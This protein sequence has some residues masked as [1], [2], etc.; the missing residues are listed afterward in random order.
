MS[1]IVEI[2][3]Q[4]VDEASGTFDNIQASGSGAADMITS[5]WKEI[6]VAAGAAGAGLELVARSQQQLTEDTRKLASATGESEEAI[7]DLALETSNVT[8]PLQDVL[9]LM[10]QAHALGI[11]GADGLQQYA[12]FW[13]MVADATGGNAVAL[14]EAGV[15]LRALG[16]EAGNESEALDAF[17][18]I[19]QNTT[20]SIEDFLRFVERSGPELRDMGM[21]VDDTAAMLGYLQ[22]EFGMSARVARTEFEQAVN[23]SGGSMEKLYEILG[24]SPDKFGEYQQAVSDSS[25]VIETYRDINN[26]TYTTLQKLQHMVSET[27]YKFGDLI[28]GIEPL[29]PMLMGVAPAVT[30]FAQLAPAAK[31]AGGFLPL[32]SGGLAGIIPAAGGVVAALLPFLPVIL[33]LIAAGAALYYAWQTNFLGIQDVVASAKDWIS[34][35]FDGIKSAMEPVKEKLGELA[36]KVGDAFGKLFGKVDELFKK[37]SGGVS[38]MEFVSKAFEALGRVMDWIWEII[39]DKLTVAIDLLTEGLVWLIEQI[40][41]VVDWFIKLAE[42]PIVSWLI[43]KVGAAVGFVG[44]QFDKILP[45]IENADAAM[46]DTTTTADGLTTT[47]SDLGDTVATAGGLMDTTMSD[48]NLGVAESLNGMNTAA[49]ETGKVF[50]ATA[51]DIEQSFTAMLTTV[52]AAAASA[53]S[54][55]TSGSAGSPSGGGS[56]PPPGEIKP[57]PGEVYAY[58]IPQGNAGSIGIGVNGAPVPVD[59]ISGNYALMIGDSGSWGVYVKDSGMA[60]GWR[61]MAAGSSQNPITQYMS[62][63]PQAVPRMARGGTVTEGG[64]VITGEEGPE[65]AYLPKGAQVNSSRTPLIDYDELARAIS[66]VVGK[67]SAGHH[68]HIGTMIADKNGIRKLVR[69]IDA[70]LGEESIRKGGSST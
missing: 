55:A 22:K 54:I 65:L 66:R 42:N 30:I 8:F 69:E 3:V 67:G 15:A 4:A 11:E 19:T 70:V 45:P 53:N 51:N 29:A 58:M 48:T 6:A 59:Y 43:D 36:S 25:G 26:D 56:G 49:D 38:I 47:F 61:T 33:L 2:I 27:A 52:R 20:M 57:Y 28:G 64:I 16:I 35:R 40:G 18:Y 14:G 21:D 62:L 12:N 50:D 31:A 10:Q 39:G 46:T 24:V 63:F 7:R 1:N 5:H 41:K 32:I 44:E 23:E 34:D 60:G 37:F 68:W 13:D 9:E 17:G